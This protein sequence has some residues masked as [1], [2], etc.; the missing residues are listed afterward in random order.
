MVGKVRSEISSSAYSRCIIS[1]YWPLG[2]ALVTTVFQRL[3]QFR[4]SAP[5]MDAESRLFHFLKHS[6]RGMGGKPVWTDGVKW[7]KEHTEEPPRRSHDQNTFSRGTVRSTALGSVHSSLQSCLS[8]KQE[9]PSMPASRRSTAAQRR[10]SW[11]TLAQCH[12]GGDNSPPQ[13]RKQLLLF[14]TQCNWANWWLKITTCD[15]VTP[16]T[17]KMHL[18][19]AKW[20]QPE[21]GE[22]RRKRKGKYM[23]CPAISSN[24][25][26]RKKSR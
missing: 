6:L 22:V 4:N 2:T 16:N 15:P 20:N 8:T 21:K 14:P 7:S 18:L 13:L 23:E 26:N 25:A 5:E 24:A 9:Q 17:V 3:C 12:K 10:N 11:H 19:G 1:A